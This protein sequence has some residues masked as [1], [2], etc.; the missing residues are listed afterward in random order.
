MS[1]KQFLIGMTMST[2]MPKFGP[3]RIEENYSE[4]PRV[5]QNWNDMTRNFILLRGISALFNRAT[6]SLATPLS[7]L[8]A[9][10][11]IGTKFKFHFTRY[12]LDLDCPLALGITTYIFYHERADF[13]EIFPE[14]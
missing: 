9:W 4:Q 14:D 8:F 3:I 1:T 6:F 12:E 2:S 7:F 10:P 11:F 5:K 13:L